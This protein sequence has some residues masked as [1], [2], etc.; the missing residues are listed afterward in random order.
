MRKQRRSRPWGVMA[1]LRNIIALVCATH[2][3]LAAQDW[4]EAHLKRRNDAVGC[5]FVAL[6]SFALTVLMFTMQG[7]ALWMSPA[8]GRYFRHDL[9]LWTQTATL[10]MPGFYGAMA[11]PH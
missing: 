9:L 7:C 6:A 4:L 3:L 10:L 2:L 1:L 5:L 8:A 11:W